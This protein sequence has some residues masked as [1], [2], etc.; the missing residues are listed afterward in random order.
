MGLPQ[1]CPYQAPT[2]DL[3]PMT[4]PPDHTS[5]IVRV[6]FLIALSISLGVFTKPRHSGRVS[7]VNRYQNV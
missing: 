7:T 2:I 1:S 6:I 3:L 5:V 4:F